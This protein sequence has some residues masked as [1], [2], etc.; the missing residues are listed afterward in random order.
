MHELRLNPGKSGHSS[1]A[2]SRA[3][4]AFVTTRS[5]CDERHD[6]LHAIIDE[7]VNGRLLD[8]VDK[9]T[10][11][12]LIPALK[13]RKQEAL[14]GGDYRQSQRLED[15]IQ[16]ANSK[17]VEA[18]YHSMQNSRLT[19]LRVQ[20]LKAKEDLDAAEEFW[21][22]AKA[23]HDDE[24]TT[25]LK[26]LEEQHRQQLEDFDHSFPEVL[27]ANFRKLSP[28]L[29]QLREQERH[30]VLTKRYEDAIPFRQRADKLEQEELDAQRQKFT[31]AF[32]GQKQQLVDTQNSQM[33]CFRK[34]WE[35]KLERFE[36]EKE[37]EM[38]VLHRTIANFEKKIATI[39]GDTEIATGGRTTPR[40]IARVSAIPQTAP[41]RLSP[42]AVNPRVRNVAA[43]KIAQKKCI[44]KRV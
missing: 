16:E 13:D 28:Q 12:S 9:G 21:R 8:T 42:A 30:L 44:V 36:R 2:S 17:Y 24:Y 31:T 33:A 10:L 14:V 43:T 11:G 38:V 37:H 29:L 25:S 3:D 22:Q 35:R 40:G 6:D 1:A 7:L 15:L 20:L 23:Q 18:T 4:S 19:N 32:Q 34:N 26:A 41:P 27:P 39:E 5:L